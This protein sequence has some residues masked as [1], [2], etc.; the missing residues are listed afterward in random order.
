MHGMTQ[1][2]VLVLEVLANCL[3]KT[4]PEVMSNIQSAFCFGRLITDSRIMVLWLM[5]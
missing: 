5:R 3:K 2:I 4:L 1:N